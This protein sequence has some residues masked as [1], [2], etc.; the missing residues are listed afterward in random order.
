MKDISFQLVETTSESCEELLTSCTQ[1]FPGFLGNAA[2][3][4]G[5]GAFFWKLGLKW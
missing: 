2:Q 4:Y 3:K 5:L 1:S